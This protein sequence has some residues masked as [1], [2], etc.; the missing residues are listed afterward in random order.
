L[1]AEP[2]ENKPR[3][4]FIP[5]DVSVPVSIQVFVDV[6]KKIGPYRGLEHDR[7]RVYGHPSFF[8][9]PHFHPGMGVGIFKG[10]NGTGGKCSAETSHQP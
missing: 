7:R 2:A 5:K 1:L 3:I 4:E 6:G 8:L 10:V 9:A